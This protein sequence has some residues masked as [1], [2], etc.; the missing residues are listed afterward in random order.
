[1]AKSTSTVT[2]TS[3]SPTGT[4]VAAGAAAPTSNR[5]DGT[6][7]EVVRNPEVVRAYLGE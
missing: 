4:W 2:D 1:M 3:S 5:A 6:P 7:D